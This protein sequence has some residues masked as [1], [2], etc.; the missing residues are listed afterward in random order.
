[1]YGN[2]SIKNNK[3]VILISILIVST[4]LFCVFDEKG[5]TTYSFIDNEWGGVFLAIVLSLTLSIH[6]W[7]KLKNKS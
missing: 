5:G 6:K 2:H 3:I 4:I 7:I 1:M